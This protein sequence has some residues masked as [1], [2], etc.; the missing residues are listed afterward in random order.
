MNLE[1]PSL[2]GH[3]RSQ[4]RARARRLSKAVHM[5]STALLRMLNLFVILLLALS[6][7]LFAG[8]EDVNAM[9]SLVEGYYNILQA[10]HKQ[11]IWL[12]GGHGLGDENLAQFV[13]VMIHTVLAQEQAAQ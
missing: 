13:D 4:Y 10:P 12:E 11:L 6:V 5:L 7:Y 9:S 2:T 3:N 1:S 8:R